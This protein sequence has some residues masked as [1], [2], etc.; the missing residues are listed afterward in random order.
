VAEKPS[1]P[2]GFGSPNVPRPPR[3]R[4]L[5]LIGNTWQLFKSP[6]GFL[7]DSYRAFGSAYQVVLKGNDAIVLAGP[8]VRDLYLEAGDN[9]LDRAFFYEP[10]QRELEA[11]EL[12][13]RTKGHRHR[14]MRRCAGLAFSRHVAA[15]HMP[16]A[17]AAM[18]RFFER[19]E[20]GRS[21]D[22]V[23]LAG[24]ALI[25]SAGPMVGACDLQTI[26]PEAYTYASTMMQVA[27]R[28]RSRL[29][30]FSPGYRRA[31]RASIRFAT[32]L[33]QQWRRGGIA[34]SS[35]N[36]II[37]CLADAR[38]DEGRA[39]PDVDIVSLVLLTFVGVGVYI[40]RVVAFMLFEL[41]RDDDLRR[42]VMSEVDAGF[43]SGFSYE[44]LRDMN[45]LHAVYCEALRRYPIWLLV[46]F[47]AEKD[48]VFDGKQVLRGDVLLISSV[49]EHFLP[50]LYPD[51]ERFDPD[52]CLPPRNEHL[53]RGAFAPF[54]S[55]ARRCIATGQTEILSLLYVA[56]LLSRARFTG[57]PG[58]A[59]RLR[60]NPLPAPH[61]FKLQFDGMREPAHSPQPAAETR[62]PTVEQLANVADR[63]VFEEAE[64]FTTIVDSEMDVRVFA[65]GADVFRQGDVADAFYV[66]ESGE[67][68]VL[69]TGD[70]QNEE[71]LTTLGPGDIFGELGL[72]RRQ[73]RSA[74]IRVAPGTERLVALKCSADAFE[75]L[76]GAL[77]IVGEELVALIRRRK[78][79]G[80]LARLVPSL[81]STT[82]RELLPDADFRRGRGGEIFVREGEPADA[83]HIIER[84]RFEVVAE[85][86]PGAEHVLARLGKADFFGEMGLIRDAPRS[87]TVRVAADCDD[88]E[89]LV[90]GKAAFLRLMEP[91]S[92]FRERVFNELGRRN[93][94]TRPPAGA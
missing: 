94:T 91:G 43:A 30:L 52:R 70:A 85:T 34:D 2:A 66:I 18:V 32:E 67:A 80:S 62:P 3:V 75:R 58:Y 65:A 92:S 10:L 17:A 61:R 89:T 1:C 41:F 64:T 81:D 60:I 63:L 82:I 76:L 71:H 8:N 25:C 72:L 13:F 29:A 15:E 44:A 74:T 19:L 37:A 79:A 57:D 14:E 28:A 56:V 31:K 49:Q 73:P 42:R 40:N 77:N 24:E 48:F 78:V 33:L 20:P 54:G 38:D 93:P 47:R 90:V 53:R 84:G 46:P 86:V 45:L 22:A 88:A 5:P 26:A 39:L 68:L 50:G 35:T 36:Y 6:W 51:P 27:A 59:L 12:I 23:R 11:E 4:G 87:A 55:G 16:A 83:F 9:F 69:R 21:Y 7:H